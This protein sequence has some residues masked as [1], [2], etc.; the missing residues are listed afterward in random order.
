VRERE[1]ELDLQRCGKK[2]PCQPRDSIDA[3]GRMACLVRD[4]LG[5]GSPLEG[6]A[7]RSRASP[8]S[9]AGEAEGVHDGL[10]RGERRD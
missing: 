9:R 7:E 8:K 10:M 6:D 2:N 1:A 4:G 3:R 5:V